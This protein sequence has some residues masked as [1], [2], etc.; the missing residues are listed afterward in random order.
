MQGEVRNGKKYNSWQVEK[1]YNTFQH[2]IK[3]IE[4]HV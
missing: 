1:K 4:V 2:I 3:L